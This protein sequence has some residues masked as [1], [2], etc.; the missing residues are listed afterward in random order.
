MALIHQNPTPRSAE[1]SAQAP[2][3]SRVYAIGDIHGR[4][5]LLTRLHR[6]IL[7]DAGSAP[8]L[9][10]VVVYL[11]D[12]VDR[13]PDSSG[14][15]DILINRPLE[16]FEVHHLKGN[17]EDMMI[18][19]L[20]TGVC[21]EM[22]MTINGVRDTL[23]SYGL[24]LSDAAPYRDDG[25]SLGRAFTDAVPQSHRKFLGGLELHH[26]EGDYLFVHAGLKPGV[27]MADQKEEDL[28]WIRDEF[29]RTDTDFGA[30]VVH[31][32]SI[33][34][35]PDVRPNRIGIDTGAWRTGI[36]TAVVLEGGKVRFLQT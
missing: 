19:F 28:L 29:T 4:A 25:N 16:G 26:T 7:D 36:L 20:E 22:S 18:A 1:G 12:Y 10:K 13:G 3:G 9:R 24:G 14:V 31:G 21:S 23:D 32:H 11:G 17:H 34:M 6:H 33:R 8:G 2:P 30:V 5:D 15:I 27:A 35:E